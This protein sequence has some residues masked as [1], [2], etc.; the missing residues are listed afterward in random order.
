[1]SYSFTEKKRIRKEFGHRADILPV[2]YLLATQVESYKSFLQ[3]G[4]PAKGRA[5]AGLHA[6]LSSVFPIRSHSGNAEIA[7][8]DYYFGEPAF[9]VRECQIRGLSYGAPLRVKM[10]LVIYDRDAPAGSKVVKDIREQDVYL[11]EIPLMTESGT[12]VINGTERVIVSQLHRSPGVFFDH[13]KGKTSS[14]KKILF[15][16]RIIPYRGSWLDFEFDQKDILYARIDRRRKIPASIILRA[17]GYTNQNMLDIF[18][19]HD[20]FRVDADGGLALTLV[21]DRLKGTDAAFDIDI[22]GENLIKTGK[23][24]T[25]RHVRELVNAKVTSL[26]VPVDFVVG[27]VL[28]ADV[29]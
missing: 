12:F 24:I 20:E 18:F 22:N 26:P 28:A 29:D 16:A 4:V 15:S 17:L 2:P 9:D 27:R 19:D 23:R 11:G 5:N 14:S 8:V 10:R 25:A 6:A 1:M 13:D 21:A 7:Y 3:S